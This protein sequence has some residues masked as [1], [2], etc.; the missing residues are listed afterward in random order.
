MDKTT[1][2]NIELKDKNEKII[3]LL[4]ELEDVKIQV[5][6]R[7]KSVELQQKQIEELLEELRESKGLENDVKILVQKKMALQEENDRLREE[8]DKNFLEG[9]DDRAESEELVLIN[10]GLNDQIKTLQT[11][12]ASERKVR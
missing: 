4:V 3:E 11:Q 12:L 10:N 2:L 6:A 5:F 8:L 1:Q 7:D 9:T